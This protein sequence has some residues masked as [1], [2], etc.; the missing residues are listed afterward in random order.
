MRKL[1]T[2]L[3]TLALVIGACGGD[4]GAGDDVG[5][6]EQV[7]SGSGSDSDD[8]G[9]AI[10]DAMGAGGGGI[11]TFDGQEIVITSA[12]CILDPGDIEVGSITDEGYRVQISEGSSGMS[13]QILTPE[14]L[15]WFP[16]E[17]QGDQADYDG[18]KTF[19]SDMASYRNNQDDTTIE[20]SFTLSCP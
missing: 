17:F 16:V 18:D 3:L 12:V 5:A 8:V 11:L 9:E 2:M 20:A 15:Q 6:D 13:V 4:D 19:S 10:A 1:F 14:F 7:T